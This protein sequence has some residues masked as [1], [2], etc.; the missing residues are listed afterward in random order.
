MNPVSVS[1][2][3]PAY[4]ASATIGGTLGALAK[5]NCFQP[6]EV[7]VVDDGSV[8]DTG[9]IICTF[10]TVKYVRQDNAGPASAR[11]HGAKLALGEFLAFTDS[12]CIPH[13]DWI[14]QLMAGFGYPAPPEAGQ[15]GV[16]AGSYGTANPES[17]LARCVYKEILWRHNHLMPDYPNSFG[18]YNFCVRKNVFEAVGGFNIDYR[19]ASGEDNDLSYKITRSGWR[20][21]FQR[22][23]LVD[24][25]HPEAV[26]K[27]LKEQFR[28][29]FW[30]IK[31]YRD[32]PAMMRGDGYTFW[33]D[34]IEMPLSAC[35]FFVWFILPPF[36]VFEIIYGLIVTLCFFD[37]IFFGFV[38]L[39]RAFARL[40]GFSTGI[41]SILFKKRV[42]IFQ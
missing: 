7:I 27:Y 33:K 6:F 5:Q 24:H 11:N 12:D 3:I 41:L 2:I 40:F 42:K 15:V 21:I 9:T 32:H 19:A 25:Y 39:F 37:G 28:H 14:A 22:K 20:I 35:A 10:P 36:L 17:R 8:D 29:G 16:V 30:R 4:N 23:A 18:S 38:L 13:E 1:V 31:M 34:I 26:A